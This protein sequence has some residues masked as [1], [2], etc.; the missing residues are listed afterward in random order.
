MLISYRHKFIFIHVYK[1]AGVSIQ[2]ALQGYGQERPRIGW[3]N[4]FPSLTA[5]LRAQSYSDRYDTHITAKELKLELP[6][7][8][9]QNSYKFAFV[10]NP[11]DWQVS[12]YSYMLEHE[13]H[14]QHK[15]IA[16]MSGFEEFLEW[17]IAHDKVLQKSFVT[18]DDG[19]LIL[20]FVGRFETLAD[21]FASICSR[22]GV[23]TRL[24]RLNASSHQAYQSYYDDRTMRLVLEAFREDVELFGYTF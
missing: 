11:W 17:R 18:G 14:F 4:W 7:E 21:D 10:R 1:T 16:S 22:L 24:P 20:D 8:V 12:L 19:N 23:E 9:W 5:K 15:L 6:E 13:E 2:T 3:R